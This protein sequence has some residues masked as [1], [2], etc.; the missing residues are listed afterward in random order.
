M[1]IGHVGET[2]WLKFSVKFYSK[3]PCAT[4]QYFYRVEMVTSRQR[5]PR[6]QLMGLRHFILDAGVQATFFSA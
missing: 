5:H 4:V 6:L 1:E 3:H 2:M